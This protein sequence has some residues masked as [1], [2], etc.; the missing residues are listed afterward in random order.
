MISSHTK[1]A[2]GQW[3]RLGPCSLSSASPHKGWSRYCR[4]GPRGHV[5]GAQQAYEYSRFGWC[6]ISAQ[7]VRPGLHPLFKVPNLSKIENWKLFDMIARTTTTVYNHFSREA[8]LSSRMIRCKY[9]D[10]RVV[11][12]RRGGSNHYRHV[13][14]TQASSEGGVPSQQAHQRL[15]LQ[16]WIRTGPGQAR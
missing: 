11:I 5:R 2:D 3:P 9:P 8:G 1:S 15:L 12:L 10:L 16:S 14:T 13:G 6:S 7:V 4:R